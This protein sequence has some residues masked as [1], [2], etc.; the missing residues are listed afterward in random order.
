MDS[1]EKLPNLGKDTVRLLHEVGIDTTEQLVTMGSKEA[2]LKIKAI[3]PSACL[4]RLQG[5]EGAIRG[6]KK[7]MLPPDVKQD[8]KDFYNFHK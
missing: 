3:D 7:G 1:L 6:I 5:L 4:L 8:L 2:W